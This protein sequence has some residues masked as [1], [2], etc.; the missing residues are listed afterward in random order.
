MTKQGGVSIWDNVPIRRSHGINRDKERREEMSGERE[1][2]VG[3][4]MYCGSQWGRRTVSATRGEEKNREKWLDSSCLKLRLWCRCSFVQWEG[5]RPNHGVFEEEWKASPLEK[6]R[7]L[8]ESGN[9]M[10][11]WI[12]KSPSH[13]GATERQEWPGGSVSD[14]NND[15]KWMT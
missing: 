2:L 6:R 3:E 12:P 10:D 9:W 5:L 14:S 1:Q 13:G 4:S 11:H 8:R 7:E 15:S